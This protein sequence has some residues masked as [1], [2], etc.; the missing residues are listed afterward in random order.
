LFGKKKQRGT[1][2]TFRTGVDFSVH[3]EDAA[4]VTNNNRHTIAQNNGLKEDIDLGRELGE[5]LGRL[6]SEWG[7]F[8]CG[9]GTDCI[10]R[11]KEEV[12]KTPIL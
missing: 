11:E 2:G 6:G 1:S 10:T 12:H 3:I 4:L 5:N 7:P 8:P 9:R